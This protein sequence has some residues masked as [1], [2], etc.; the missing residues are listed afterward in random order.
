MG[1]RPKN[2]RERLCGSRNRSAQCQEV[3]NAVEVRA[4]TG[5]PK[6]HHQKEVAGTRGGREDFKFMRPRRQGRAPKKTPAPNSPADSKKADRPDQS[7]SEGTP[8][9]WKDLPDGSP[10]ASRSR[11]GKTGRVK[12]KSR[13]VPA[14]EWGTGNQNEQKGV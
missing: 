14:K 6:R 9:V 2:S 12:M 8:G 11:K 10:R 3:R 13:G 7:I 1:H 4:Q 5:A